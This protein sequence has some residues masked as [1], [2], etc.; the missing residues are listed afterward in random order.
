MSFA[1]PL[2]LVAEAVSRALAEDVGRGDLTTDT[3]I[4][5]DARSSARIMAREAGIVAG[6]DLAEHAFHEMRSSGAFERIVADGDHVAVGDVIA[7]VEGRTRAL[8]SA[9]RVALNF[10]TH[11]SGI[12]TLT[13]RYVEAVKGTKARIVDTRKTLPGLRALQKYAVRAGGG[14]NHRF[15]LD[16]AVMLKDNHII[17]GGGVAQAIARVRAGI[18][19]MVKICCEVDRLDQIE[20]ALSAGADVILLDNMD[21]PAL[22]EA[23]RLIA[24]R[25]I[26]E[27]SG[28]VS[29]ETVRAIAESGVDV[30]SIG[31]LTH[32]APALDIALDFDP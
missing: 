31:K 18:G 30:I 8:L 21:P 5:A 25:A 17:A 12:A 10:L 22:T 14:A 4:D 28:K 32:S 29:L 20:P 7:K 24:G 6:L 23:V 3:L 15:G 13:N 2:R 11:L 27:A 1:L 16:D 9:E 26:A 19:H